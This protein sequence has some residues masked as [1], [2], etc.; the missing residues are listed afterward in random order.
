MFFFGGGEFYLVLLQYTGIP[1]IPDLTGLKIGGF[2][3]EIFFVLSGY[4]IGGIL[5]KTLGKENSVK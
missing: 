5:L 1:L 3:V 2:G 4:L